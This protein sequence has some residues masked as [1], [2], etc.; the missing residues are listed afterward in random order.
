ELISDGSDIPVFAFA[1]RD[2][3]SFSVFDMSDK[4]RERGWLLPAYT[5]PKNR[6]DLAVLRAVCKEG[7][8][9]DMADA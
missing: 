2:A 8:T 3:A 6:E 9:R 4:L 1:A 7:F 5:F